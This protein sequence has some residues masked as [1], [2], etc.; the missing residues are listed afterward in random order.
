MRRVKSG[1][2]GFGCRSMRVPHLKGFFSSDPTNTWVSPPDSQK[3]RPMRNFRVFI[4]LNPAHLTKT[5]HRQVSGF[6]LSVL[7]ASNFTLSLQHTPPD[8]PTILAALGQFWVTVKINESN[9]KWANGL[10]T[11]KYSYWPAITYSPS[12][13]TKYLIKVLTWVYAASECCWW[14][15]ATLEMLIWWRQINYV[16]RIS[17]AWNEESE[18]LVPFSI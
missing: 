18:L 3:W 2:T 10:L 14:I 15:I 8:G 16:I 17:L 7:T 5:L 12:C 9:I 6:E 11:N 1:T 13:L 4:I